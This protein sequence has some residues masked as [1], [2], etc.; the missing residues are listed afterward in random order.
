MNVMD[1]CIYAYIE[2]SSIIP[3]NAYPLVPRFA[4][5]ILYSPSVRFCRI[6]RRDW[7]FPVILAKSERGIL[8]FALTLP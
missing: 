6:M 5:F 4:A 8:V 1:P 7:E 2:S 3:D